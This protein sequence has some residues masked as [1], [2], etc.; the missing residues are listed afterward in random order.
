LKELEDQERINALVEQ[1]V[2]RRLLE[3]RMERERLWV[4][5]RELERRERD[6][7][8]ARIRKSHQREMHRLK[9]KYEG[10]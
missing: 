3:E 2:R 10:K 6:V 4:N 1:E 5:K 7:E 8:M 9:K